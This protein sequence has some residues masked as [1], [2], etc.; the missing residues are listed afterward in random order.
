MSS[1]KCLS[2]LSFAVGGKEGCGVA[3]VE[4][5]LVFSTSIRPNELF[6]LFGFS[7]LFASL[8]CPHGNFA[9]AVLPVHS[10]DPVLYGGN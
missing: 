3:P 2:V 10:Q 9:E 4:A 8:I 5:E 1:I 7:F 6:S